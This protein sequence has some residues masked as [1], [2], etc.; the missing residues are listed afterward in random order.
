MSKWAQ[1]LINYKGKLGAL[2]SSPILFY[3]N[4]NL[5]EMVMKFTFAILVLS[6]YGSFVQCLLLNI[7][8]GPEY[9]LGQERRH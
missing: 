2:V 5:A 3:P 8:F 7:N 1:K 4:T 6:F 9:V